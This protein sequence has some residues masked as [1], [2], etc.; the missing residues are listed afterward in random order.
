[1][2][3]VEYSRNSVA[4]HAMCSH[5]SYCERCSQCR[6]SVGCEARYTGAGLGRPYLGTCGCEREGLS[7]AS[8]P[9]IRRW[10]RH[11]ISKLARSRVGKSVWSVG[12]QPEEKQT[13]LRCRAYSRDSRVCMN[14]TWLRSGTLLQNPNDSSRVNLNQI[15]NLK[16]RTIY[17]P[18]GVVLT[19]VHTVLGS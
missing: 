15:L 9:V 12:A 11:A 6:S 1:M 3:V 10:A 16:T 5:E 7:A 14:Y 19:L 18:G 17:E 13:P 8:G 4:P 2:D